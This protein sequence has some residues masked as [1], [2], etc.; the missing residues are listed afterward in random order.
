MSD[1]KERLHAPK[2]SDGFATL[3]AAMMERAPPSIRGAKWR[4][5][6]R[7]DPADARTR[8]QTLPVGI[9]ASTEANRTRQDGKPYGGLERRV[10]DVSPVLE[11]RRAMPPRIKVS[12]RLEKYRYAR[13]RSAAVSL[14]RTHQDLMTSALDLYLDVLVGRETGKPDENRKTRTS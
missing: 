3:S 12:V 6:E 14:G 8:K 11:R 4:D 2:A 5:L 1:H 13:L 7:C 10:R 9:L